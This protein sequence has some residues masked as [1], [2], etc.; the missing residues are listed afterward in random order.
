M[1]DKLY[2]Y[3]QKTPFNANKFHF[4]SFLIYGIYN[5][6]NFF[7]CSLNIELLKK[8]D[9]CRNEIQKQ[10]DMAFLMKRIIFFERSLRILFEDHQFKG[11]H[12]H[13]K[14]TLKEAQE[15]R[16]YYRLRDRI[17]GKLGDH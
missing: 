15:L 2:Y 11:L 9:E 6:C 10:F 13:D 17:K 7:G 3:D 1:G 12:M 16:S 4:V 8:F 5:L 14:M